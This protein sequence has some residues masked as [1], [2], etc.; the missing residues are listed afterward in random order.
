MAIADTGSDI[1]WTQCKPCI[2][3][4]PQD[5]PLFDPKKSST[6]RDLSCESQPCQESGFPSC[7]HSNACQYQITYGD[8][9]YS[10][11]LLAQETFTFESTSGRPVLLP[12][13]VF[14]C[15]QQNQGTFNESSSGIVGL[16]GGSLSLVSQLKDSIN[17]KFS[18]C[19]V[20]PLS[21]GRDLTS[22]IFFGDRA[23]V[24]GPGVV[25]TPIIKNSPDTFY[26]LT[27]ESISV[28]NK[29][30]PTSKKSPSSS[31]KAAEEGNIIIDSG[32]T[33]TLLPGDLYQ[34]LESELRQAIKAN[35]KPDPSGLLSLCYDGNANFTVPPIRVQFTGAELELGAE[36]TFVSQGDLVCL[37]MVPSR[38]LAIFGNLSQMN[39]LIGYDLENNKLSF[40]PTDCSKQ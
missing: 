20:N 39:F 37:A 2:N 28:G 29:T 31:E 33:L 10:I 22:D 32:T 11:G 8:H 38:D 15:G 13:L 27:L 5:A 21:S 23:V 9:S 24:S 18:Y 34:D 19:L 30:F 6:Y 36:S 12:K 1:T 4:Y 7:T 3:C 17:G 16:G 35:P 40:K 14:G 26:Y 25:S